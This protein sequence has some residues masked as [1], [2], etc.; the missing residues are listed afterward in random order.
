MVDKGLRT[1]QEK[2]KGERNFGVWRGL[3]VGEAE[4]EAFLCLG[5]AY[6]V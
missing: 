4:S 1:G 6:P 3:A 2:G 5:L